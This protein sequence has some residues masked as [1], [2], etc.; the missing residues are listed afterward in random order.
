MAR[1]SRLHKAS[2][3]CKLA[4]ACACVLECFS[5][6]TKTSALVQRER[7]RE[8]WRE[9]ERE[10]ER[11]SERERDRKRERE[12][13]RQRER[14]T[15]RGRD[16]EREREREREIRPV[17]IRLGLN[18]C[19]CVYLMWVGMCSVFGSVIFRCS[20]E[21][22]L[23]RLKINWVLQTIESEQSLKPYTNLIVW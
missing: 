9:R 2:P 21:S 13:E 10:R 1:H 23:I 11:E 7:E 14:E 20:Y 16:R 12:R 17:I 22:W 19:A 15:E 3:I 8:R 4:C 5:L 18:V 6:I